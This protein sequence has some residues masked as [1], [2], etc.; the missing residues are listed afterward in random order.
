VEGFALASAHNSRAAK[1]STDMGQQ[2]RWQR[3]L[4]CCLL[5]GM[6]ASSAGC[7]SFCHPIDPACPELAEPCH[8]LP[9]CARD[10]VYIFFIHGMDPADF[11]NLSGVCD[12]VQSLGFHK[13]YYGQLYHTH[14]FKNTLHEIHEQDCNARFVL[15]GFSFGANMVRNLALA[16]KD[17]GIKIDLLV[18]LGGN[19]LKNKAD[20]QP[21]N[22]LRI[23][24]ILAQGCI[25]NGATMDRAEN[26][27][28]IGRWHFGSPT[29]P[30]TLQVLAQDLAE[31]AASIPVPAAP[32][33]QMPP[34][35][36]TAPTPRKVGKP[37][38]QAKD[39]WD[40]LKPAAHLGEQPA[41]QSPKIASR[42]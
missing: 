13:T 6:L 11:A 37:G 17:E 8:L 38:P 18:Y 36:E 29:H 2:G 40:F 35:D 42:R 5:A 28:V 39:E 41:S 23:V 12:Y 7:L 14:Q 26:V 16:A 9:K 15:V 21:D 30:F 3:V 34:W 24:N 25:W 19:T 4:A 1:G 10:H 31:I 20:D 27:Q 32:D 22:V 33:R